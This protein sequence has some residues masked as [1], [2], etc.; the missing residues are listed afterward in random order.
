MTYALITGAAKRI[1]KSIAIFLAKQGW[2]IVIHYNKS[3]NEAVKLQRVIERTNQKCILYQSN[4]SKLENNNCFNPCAIQRSY[5][6]V[7]SCLHFS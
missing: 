4:F 3:Y 5:K 1:G 7:K 2:D 6:L